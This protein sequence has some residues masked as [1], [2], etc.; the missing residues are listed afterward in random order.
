MIVSVGDFHRRNRT[1]CSGTLRWTWGSGREDSVGFTFTDRDGP[2]FT[3]EYRYSAGENVRIPVRL[4]STD[5]EFN[6]SRWWFTCP[7]VVNGVACNRRIGKLYLPANAKFFGC[8]HCHN[9]TYRSCQEAHQ[10]ERLSSGIAGLE[11]L[12]NRLKSSCR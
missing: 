3:L 10:E 7:L 4:Q 9:L 8:R 5:T 6:G 1:R 11:R 2:T 12:V